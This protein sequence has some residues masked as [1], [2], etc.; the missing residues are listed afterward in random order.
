MATHQHQSVHD[1]RRALAQ[2][3]A[4]VVVWVVMGS[5]V[6][7]L[8]EDWS[9]FEALFFVLITVT[10]VGYGDQGISDVGRWV[11]I[12]LMLGGV[13]GTTYSFALMVQV[14]LVHGADWRWRMLRSI[15]KL[16]EHAVVLGYGR[17]GEALAK[18]LLASGLDVVV[19][20]GLEE[21]T[22]AARV[23][24]FYVIQGDATDEATLVAAGIG[25]ASALA[26]CLDRTEMSLAAVLSAR[27]LNT[28]AR[29][30]ARISRP[31]EERRMRLAGADSVV[32]PLHAGAQDAARLLIRS[33][34]TELL[35][36][37]MEVGLDLGVGEVHVQDGS[38]LCGRT[39]ANIGAQ[40]VRSVSFVALFR[41]GQPATVRP[42]SATVLRPDDNI[43][44][45]GPSAE[46]QW[47]VDESRQKRAA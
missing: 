11:T 5:T 24:G 26:V 43:V 36:N 41:D 37:H 22:D 45:V 27:D 23:S 47:L 35:A 12:L 16:E 28:G 39:L 18:E 3:L 32:S 38:A 4:L 42:D 31:N 6:L 19:I 20:D 2:A 13:G 21:R 15:S 25:R 29:I 30:V 33:D 8:L 40:H 44:L 46:V 17:M 9:F 1:A 7:T 34:V 10:T 14:V